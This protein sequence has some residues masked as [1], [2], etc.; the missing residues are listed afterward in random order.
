[1]KTRGLQIRFVLVLVASAAIFSALT[2][3]M[4]YWLGYQRAL[5]SGRQS[6]EDLVTA[7][8]KTAAV[9]A[10]AGDKVLMQ[11][12]IDGLASNRLVHSVRIVDPR[13]QPVVRRGAPD[14]AA[15]SA[16]QA[17]G[18]E[19]PVERALL[20][21][22][23][24]NQV[25]GRL[26]IRPNREVIAADG[27][28]QAW[29]LVALLVLQV[30]LV[31]GVLYLTAAH[32]VSRP[33]VRLAR[34]LRLMTP[35]SAQ[36]LET[37]DEHTQDEI[38]VLIAGANALL[39]A[40]AVTLGRERALR[41]EVERME[42]Q[43]RQIFDSTSAGIFLLDAQGRL[44]NGNPT[45]LKVLALPLADVQQL[46][47]E[48]F[49]TAAFDDPEHVREMIRQAAARRETL[50]GDLR[51]RTH[52][53][54]ARW[55]HCLIS[56][57]QAEV[58][59]SMAAGAASAAT[60][61]MLVEGVMYDI[62][63]RKQAERRVRHQAEHDVLT[64]LKN[65]MASDDTIDRILAE[66]LV[67]GESATLLFIDLD[68]FKQVNDTLGH[69][70]GDEVLRECAERMRRVVRRST[71][72]VGRIGGDEFVVVLRHTGPEDTMAVQVAQALLQSLPQP[73]RLADGREARVGVS[74]G[75]ASA[76]LHGHS[77]RQ[78]E[79]AA[80]QALY[81]VKRSGK[82]AYAMALRPREPRAAEVSPAQAA[83][84]VTP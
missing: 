59:A 29:T 68:G 56:V 63:D 78:I 67:G 32:F 46:R 51:L 34:E 28:R 4:A 79:E 84:E 76:P 58:D 61:P 42:A 27:Q 3:T 62:T 35:G 53:G 80:D 54:A 45:V 18:D 37:P 19:S 13:G 11:E 52:D 5:E 38:G 73:V 9:G 60:A 48:D 15:A 6:I 22:F 14:E 70:A 50:S 2:G 25:T 30:A 7:V 75:M 36:R 20:S 21:P 41:A 33:I 39:E 77:R 82:Q 12:V 31:A 44:I 49:L 81:A 1:M 71:D 47:G 74:I 24:K 17:L 57:Q 43:Y 26:L 16:S 10:F 40:N 72:L 66:S 69:S 8:E 65:R 23:D 55:V 64:G 83:I